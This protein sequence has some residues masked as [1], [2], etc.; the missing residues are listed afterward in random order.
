MDR[1]SVELTPE[2]LTL[3]RDYLRL[4]RGIIAKTEWIPYMHL[5]TTLAKAQDEYNKKEGI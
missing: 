4:C 1:I 2:E 3:A 5:M